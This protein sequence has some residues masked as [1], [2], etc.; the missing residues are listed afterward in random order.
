MPRFNRCTKGPVC[1]FIGMGQFQIRLTPL[2]AGAI[3]WVEANDATRYNR[4]SKALRQIEADPSYKGLRT[5]PFKGW[6]TPDGTQVF[7]SYV[8]QSKGA[9]RIWWYYGKERHLIIV[10]D[11]GPHPD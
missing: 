5:H 3:K 6:K 1:Y 8:D 10:L 11:V 7:Q 9:W 4:I 2:A